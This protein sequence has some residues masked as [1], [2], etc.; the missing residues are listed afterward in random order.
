MSDEEKTRKT[1]RPPSYLDALIPIITLIIL[2]ASAIYLYGADG[3]SGPI[4]VALMISMMVA[5]LVGLKNGPIKPEEAA[6]QSRL[7]WNRWSMG[8]AYR[9]RSGSHGLKAIVQ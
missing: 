6:G 4:Q 7:L 1:I 3:T 2:P 9:A 5:G 8:R